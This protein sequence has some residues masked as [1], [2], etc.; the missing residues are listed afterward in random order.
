MQPPS[1]HATWV[2]FRSAHLLMR[3]IRPPKTFYNFEAYPLDPWVSLPD[4]GWTLPRIE[5]E[6]TY[7]LDFPE[8]VIYGYDYEAADQPYLLEIWCEKSTMNDVLI[9]LCQEYGASFGTGLGFLSITAVQGLIDRTRRTAK[10]CRVMYV[11][12]FDPAGSFM[13][14]QIARQIEFWLQADGLN[15]DIALEPNRTNPRAD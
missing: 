14:Q 10:P 13:P 8:P 7:S 15:L 9:P 12:D 11:A 4:E 5:P 1:R 2:W 3:A 6:L